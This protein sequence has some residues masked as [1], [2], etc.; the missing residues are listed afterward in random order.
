MMNTAKL[1]LAAIP[2]P[3]PGAGFAE[4][5]DPEQ[6]LAEAARA[7]LHR[8]LG[9]SHFEASER[10]RR[11]LEYVVEETLAGRADRIKAYMPA[12]RNNI[13]LLLAHKSS[14]DLAGSEGKELLAKQIR[15]ESLRAM[16]EEVDDDEDDAAATTEAAS[17][18]TPARKKKK[19]KAA[20]ADAP[21]TSVQ[22]SS[23]IIQ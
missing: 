4:A 20:V 8:V 11:F 6:C 9:S 19:K 18:A 15:R 23:F 22:F 16:G 7:E 10:N 13:L 1:R 14:A 21:I 5:I 12:I 3:E 17:A 2:S